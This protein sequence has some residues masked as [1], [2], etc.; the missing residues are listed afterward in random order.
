MPDQFQYLAIGGGIPHHALLR[1]AATQQWEAIQKALLTEWKSS[2]ES[3]VRRRVRNLSG[4]LEK[5]S[6]SLM[7]AHRIR[8]HH[9]D[10]LCQ[11]KALKPTGANSA[12][13]HGANACADF[14]ALLLQARAALDRLAWYVTSQF[15]NPSQSFRTI[16]NVLA[17]FANR[18]DEAKELIEIIKK[19]DTWFDCTF[20]QLDAP[21]SLRDLVA[22]NH[23]LI[24]G[25]RTCFGINRVKE[26]SVLLIDCEIQLPG[27]N[28]PIPVITTA[29][30]TVKWLSYIVLNVVAVFTKVPRLQPDAYESRWHNRTVAISRFVIDQPAGSPLGPYTLHSVR[31]MTPDGFV[32]GTDNVNPSIFECAVEI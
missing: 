13:M 26:N 25:V 21:K 31:T 2:E 30:E 18:N 19:A 5:L 10:L 4:C 3:T 9:D 20:G 12:A 17:D 1:D 14:E 8:N 23:A 11:A 27:L 16:Q 15:R 29:N 22:H 24:E 28:T 6:A 32:L 7:Q